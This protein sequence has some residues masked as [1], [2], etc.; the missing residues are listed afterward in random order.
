MGVKK[1]IYAATNFLNKETENVQ[2]TALI[3]RQ[4]KIVCLQHLKTHFWQLNLKDDGEE[5]V[6]TP[7]AD[8]CC[9][10]HI[11]RQY[12]IQLKTDFELDVR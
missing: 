10:C 12:L 9:S 3:W 8:F 7:S 2:R 4:K 6:V 1:N 11:P 5:S